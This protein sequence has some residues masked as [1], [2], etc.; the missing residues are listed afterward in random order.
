MGSADGT[1]ELS[2]AFWG[3]LFGLLFLLPL[4]GVAE[5]AAV[6]TRLGLSDGFL[7]RARDRIIAGTSALFLLTD[8]AALDRVREAFAG[9]HTDLLISRFDREQVAALRRAFD[10]DNDVVIR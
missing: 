7:A 10:A 2:G 3:L 6:L 8:G 5:G 1:R 9:T 4:A